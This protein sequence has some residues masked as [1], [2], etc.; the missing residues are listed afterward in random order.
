MVIAGP[1]LLILCFKGPEGRKRVRHIGC[2][3][4][5]TVKTVKDPFPKPVVIQ[6]V[7]GPHIGEKA[8][9]PLGEE[10]LA[11]A[12]QVIGPGGKGLQAGGIREFARVIGQEMIVYDVG[13]GSGIE[14]IGGPEK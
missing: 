1:E 3:P 11:G 9:K 5:Q 6:P 12:Y 4:G 13:Q 14:A 2:P 8:G 10:G 7:L